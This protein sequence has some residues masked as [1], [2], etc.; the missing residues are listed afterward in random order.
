M[1]YISKNGFHSCKREF[2]VCLLQCEREGGEGVTSVGPLSAQTG[3]HTLSQYSRSPPTTPWLLPSERGA[4]ERCQSSSCER[5][6]AG[7]EGGTQH[8]G[9]DERNPVTWLSQL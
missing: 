5:E 4:S 7:R 3:Y 6:I 8:L 9:R 1:M 2:S